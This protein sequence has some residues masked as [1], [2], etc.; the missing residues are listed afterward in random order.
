MDATNGAID[1]CGA[2]ILNGRY[3]FEDP[4]TS[5]SFQPNIHY[6]GVIVREASGR[7][8]A[9]RDGILRVDLPNEGGCFQISNNNLRFFQDDFQF[10]GEASAGNIARIRLFDAAMTT[11]QVQALNRKLFEY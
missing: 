1:Q 5:P 10:G 11:A 8:R 4:N 7:V 2:Y 9:Y 6:Q 3:E